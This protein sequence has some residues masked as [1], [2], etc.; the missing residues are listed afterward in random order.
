MKKTLLIVLPLLLIVGCSKEPI[1][2]NSLIKR[3][4]YY[5]TKDTNKPYTGDVFLIYEDGKKKTSGSLKRGRKVK[6]WNYWY[7]NG[8][9]NVREDYF[10]DGKVDQYRYE[11]E[12]YKNGELMY[13]GIYKNGDEEVFLTNWYENGQKKLDKNYKD[14]KLEGLVTV[15]YENGQKWEEGN[16]KDGERDGLLTNW[17]ENG[18]KRHEKTYKDDEEISSKCWDKNGNEIECN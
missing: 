7:N 15:W 13:L 11:Y 16:Y 12:F 6:T 2:L 4:G 8:L 5:F 9:K 14:E 1:N 10:E 3:N 18:Q 17:Y